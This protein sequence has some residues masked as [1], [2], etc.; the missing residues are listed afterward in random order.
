MIYMGDIPQTVLRTGFA[1]IAL[2]SAAASPT[3]QQ[4]PVDLIV[5]N[6]KV[7]TVDAQNTQ[8]EAVAIRGNTFAAI[9]TTAV[10]RKLAG[11]NTRVID[12]GGRTVVPGF[13]ESH[14]H[15]T[16][17][18]RSEVSQP[19]IQL[20]S[21]QEI[22][23]WVRAR[24]KDAGPGGWVQLPRIDVTR[25]REGRLPNKADLDDAA[26]NNPTVY[27]WQYANRNIQILNDAAIRAAKINKT[28]VAPK[29][30]TLHFTPNGEFTGKMESCQSLL[31]LPQREVT[32]SRYLD[33]LAA[34]MKRYNEVGITSIGERSSNAQGFR[35]YQQLKAQGRLPL[36]VRVTIRIGT[37]DNSEA[38][39][40]RI[41]TG[42]G[43]KYDQGDDWVRVG[44]LK[45]GIDGGAL[46][47]TAVMREPY[48]S[49]SHELYGITDPKYSG[50]FGRGTG[51]TVEGVK[52]YVRVGNRLGW[53][54]SS[55]V[56]G[57]RGVD[58]V[59]D[60]IEAANKEKSMLDKR[61]NLIHA[62]FASADTARRAASLG[63][64]VD[65]QP[66]WFYKDGDALLKALGP[67]YMNTFIGVKTWKDNGVTVALNADHMMGFDPV[68]ALNPY[69]P[70]L[71]MQATITRRTQGGQVIGP[72]ER[73]SRLDALRMTTI[74]AAYIGFEEKNK[75]SIEA[76]KL[77]D[78]AI[79][80]GD[81]LTVPEDQI[82]TI[83]SYMTIVDG[84]I[85]YEA[86]PAS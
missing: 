70:L 47:G 57:D 85:V 76:G 24:A 51:L 38:T 71:A 8:A 68:G 48:P 63:A 66:M 69:H 58:I 19:F 50:E 72:A 16:G 78:L 26:P 54:L 7:L 33:S 73:I 36:R 75:G 61:Y 5:I 23:D 4:P 22:R 52:N 45:I 9:G 43:V 59:L 3:G 15:A 84:K 79:L 32:E 25:I 46:Y 18:A 31:N 81:F 39:I 12:A 67:K 64:I 17:V 80:T 34:L 1:V 20:N 53:Q 29:G 13:I 10:I 28:T 30:C 60:A 74:N 65:T 41:I 83:K 21:I 49:T 11:P 27:T 56:T 77:A 40:E 6:A 2:L 44:P 14:V 82:M 35:D 37:G 62:Y 86:K 42:L 55:H